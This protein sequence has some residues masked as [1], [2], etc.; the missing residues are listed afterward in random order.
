M[1]PLKIAAQVV[2]WYEGILGVLAGLYILLSGIDR[3]YFR[4]DGTVGTVTGRHINYSGWFWALWII[5]SLVRIVILIVLTD[6]KNNKAIAIL[7]MLFCSIPGGIFALY[8]LKEEDLS[9]SLQRA[10][11]KIAKL[12]GRVANI[13]V[14]LEASEAEAEEKEEPKQIKS[15]DIVDMPEPSEE[16][17]KAKKILASLQG[18]DPEEN[19]WGGLISAIDKMNLW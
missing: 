12:E 13:Q 11:Q 15:R 16:E 4:S 19:S 7:D 14:L 1:K 5:F 8:S 10:H 17:N 2:S 3:F 18:E 6:R 9:P